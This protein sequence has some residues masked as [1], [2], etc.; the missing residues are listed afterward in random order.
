M[1]WL[2]G[3]DWSRVF[4]PSRSLPETLLRGSLFYLALVVLLRVALKRQLGQLGSADLLVLVL[5]G[6]ASQNAL[7]GGYTSIGDGL[8][9]VAVLALWSF[10]LNWLGYRFRW[11]ERLLSP[12]RVPLVRDGR[13]LRRNMRKELITEDELFAEIRLQGVADLVEVEEARMESDGRISVITRKGHAR[14]A[15]KRDAS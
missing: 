10:S 1:H 12:E 15:P 5:L 11:I 13:M 14:G 9:L 4:V 8:L 2:I 3:M 7:A 6:D